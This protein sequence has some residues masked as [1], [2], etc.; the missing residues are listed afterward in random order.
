MFTYLLTVR[1]PHIASP[2]KIG[3]WNACFIGVCAVIVTGDTR[4]Y[5]SHANVGDG[6]ELQINHFTAQA[7]KISGLKSAHYAYK[8]QHNFQVL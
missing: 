3:V 4:N 6:R 5:G 7:C 2:L 8:K 1:D